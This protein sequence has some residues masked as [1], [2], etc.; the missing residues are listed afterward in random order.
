M[1]AAYLN[2]KNVSKKYGS[3]VVLQDVSAALEQGRIHGIVGR[4][5]SGKTVLL[6]CVCG[7]IS[8]DEGEIAIDGSTIGKDIEM[9]PSF[10]MLIENPGFLPHYSAYKNLKYLADLAKTTTARPID[11]VLR[12]VGLE[13]EAKKKVRKYSLGMKQRLG[14]AQAIMGDPQLLILDEPLSGLDQQGVMEMR[15]LLM[16]YKK[17][18]GTILMASHS[19]EDVEIL[20]DTVH[21][22]ESGRVS[23]IR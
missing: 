8:Y 21:R 15:E 14:L 18:G 4:N 12:T 7:F 19:I 2:I 5:G 16:R 20:C 3:Q 22:I 10:G 13:S 1:D 11:E 9:P 6:K 17:G 23:S